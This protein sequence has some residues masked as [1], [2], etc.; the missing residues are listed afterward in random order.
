MNKF[1]R[2]NN[3]GKSFDNDLRRLIIDECLKSGGHATFGYLPVT[4]V[5]IACRFNVSANTVSK[6]WKKILL[7][8]TKY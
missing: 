2:S 8:R 5:S 6:I 3:L 4:Y 7:R 1:G